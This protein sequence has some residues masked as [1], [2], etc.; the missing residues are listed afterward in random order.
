MDDKPDPHKSEAFSSLF[1]LINAA[2][3]GDEKEVS[4]L[5]YEVYGSMIAN[6]PSLPEDA[7][8]SI[9]TN[10]ASQLNLRVVPPLDLAKDVLQA[11]QD[12]ANIT[13][14]EA[15]GALDKMGNQELLRWLSLVLAPRLA[16]VKG[17]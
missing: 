13:E 8:L 1:N 2:R 17:W 11:M 4:R 12:V 10:L 7:R 5:T 14:L 9:L 15:V 6:I 3:K 16:P